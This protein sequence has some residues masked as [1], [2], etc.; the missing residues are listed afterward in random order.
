MGRALELHVGARQH[1]VF[2]VP[3]WC[4]GWTWEATSDSGMDRFLGA[5]VYSVCIFAFEASES[6]LNLMQMDVA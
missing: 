4:W 5:V 2:S 3:T 1:R 6:S